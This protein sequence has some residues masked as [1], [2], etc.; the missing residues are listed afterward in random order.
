MTSKLRRTSS[1]ARNLS[2]AISVLALTLPCVALQGTQADPCDRTAFAALQSCRREATSD[3][4]LQRAKCTNLPTSQEQI[5]CV[6]DALTELH[7]T[8]DECDEQYDARLELCADLGGGIYYPVIDPND[9]V[10]GIDNPYL[11]LVPGTTFTYEK[12]QGTDVETTEIMVTHDTKV[13]LGVTCT[14]LHSIESEN[15]VIA[16]DTFDWVAQDVSGNVWYFG[17]LSKEFEDGLLASLDGSWEAGVDGASPGILM[18]GSPSIGEVYRQ[19][20]LIGEAEDVGAILS[21]SASEAV[22]YGAFVNCLKT[23]DTSPLDPSALEHKF[24][25]PGVGLILELNLNS[26]SRNELVAVDFN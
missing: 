8:L 15:G 20:F 5:D 21:L 26:G 3:F 23:E 11:P 17:E 4:W 16:E 14:V 25:A 9:F 1:S 22:P 12:V 2:S 13:I 7:D 19:E 6:A 10:G 18:Q 24:Y